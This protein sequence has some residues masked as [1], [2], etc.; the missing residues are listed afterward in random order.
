MSRSSTAWQHRLILQPTA[1]DNAA[2]GDGLLMPICY[3]TTLLLW[4]ELS[5][6]PSRVLAAPAM[7]ALASAD[8]HCLQP[9]YTYTKHHRADTQL[10]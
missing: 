4:P 10:G 1:E 2:A 9:Q 6:L 8:A 7:E 5:W 3:S